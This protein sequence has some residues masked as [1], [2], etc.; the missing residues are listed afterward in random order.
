MV[1][2]EMNGENQGGLMK[3]FEKISPLGERKG[4]GTFDGFWDNTKYDTMQEALEAND[5]VVVDFIKDENGIIY[6][7]FYHIAEPNKK[8]I[9]MLQIQHF[10]AGVDIMD[11]QMACAKAQEFFK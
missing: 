4:P 3:K 6:F 1:L 9:Q 11:D 2:L 8:E 5:M 10:P 7:E